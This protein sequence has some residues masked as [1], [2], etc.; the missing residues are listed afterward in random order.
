MSIR[1]A[2]EKFIDSEDFANAIVMSTMAGTGGSGYSVEF[3][4]DG[5]YR[6]LWDNQ[7]GNLYESPGVIVKIPQLTEQELEGSD[8]HEAAELYA[9]EWKVE[10]LD[11]ILE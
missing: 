10:F 11:T 1:T 8:I 5:H 7:I 9:S 3:Y 2:A 4:P 6:V